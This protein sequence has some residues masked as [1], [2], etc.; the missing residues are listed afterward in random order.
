PQNRSP[1]LPPSGGNGSDS[2]LVEETYVTDR[3]R[4]RRRVVRVEL[5]DVRSRLGLP[6][7]SDQVDWQRI[8]DDLLQAVGESMF[9]V[10]LEP[11]ELIAVDPEGTLVLSAPSQTRSWLQ[12]RYWR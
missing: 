12:A 2:I 11:L 8:R 3:G 1:P 10:W 6:T 7:P 4:S 5:A 9:A